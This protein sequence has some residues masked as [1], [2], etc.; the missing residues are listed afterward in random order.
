MVD[1]VTNAHKS[2]L[3]SFD[4]QRLVEMLWAKLKDFKTPVWLNNPEGSIFLHSTGREL[5]KAHPDY[6]KFKW[7]WR[8]F[9]EEEIKMSKAEEKQY[10][11]YIKQQQKAKARVIKMHSQVATA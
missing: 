9:N 11:E 1:K 4:A 2:V 7:Y 10:D 8:N 5:I 3:K 6:M